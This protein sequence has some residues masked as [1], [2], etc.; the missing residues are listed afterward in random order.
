MT[1]ISTANRMKQSTFC[2]L[3]NWRS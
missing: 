2:Y 1:N 3:Q